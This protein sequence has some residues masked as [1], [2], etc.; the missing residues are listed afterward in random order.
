[1]PWND[2]NMNNGPSDREKQVFWGTFSSW[3]LSL[4]LLLFVIAV[5]HLSG[6]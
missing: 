1:M 2:K 4:I 3:V 6:L 5:I